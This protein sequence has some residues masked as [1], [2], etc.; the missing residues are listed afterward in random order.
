MGF[1]GSLV[2]EMPSGDVAYPIWTPRMFVPYPQAPVYH[3]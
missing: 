2:H 3:M 1:A